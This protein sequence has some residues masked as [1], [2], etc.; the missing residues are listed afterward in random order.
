MFVLYGVE[1]DRFENDYASF[2]NCVHPLDR[3]RVLAEVSE[4]LRE[5]NS[6]T[7][8]FRVQHPEGERT[9]AARG[10]VRRDPSGRVRILSGANWAVDS[11][12]SRAG[13][14]QETRQNLHDQSKRA[15]RIDE[16]RR[17]LALSAVELEAARRDLEAFGG[18]I[19]HEL[20]R[21]LNQLREFHRLL[22]EALEGRWSEAAARFHEVIDGCLKHLDSTLQ[23]LLELA[24]SSGTPLLLER[25][26]PFGDLF[27]DARASLESEAEGRVIE[28]T[29]GPLGSADCS[30]PLM[31]QVFHNLLSNALKFTRHEPVARISVR[32]EHPPG[33]LRIICEDNGVGFEPSQAE[34]LFQPFQR[35]HGIEEFEG[36]GLGLANVARIVE[37]HGGSLSASGVVGA[38][39]RFEVTLRGLG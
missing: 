33:F 2:E 3:Q 37:R 20:T 24:R 26:V 15:Q 21:P 13:T 12:L 29:V 9:I 23:G 28:W 35:L 17:E 10:A 8:E 4:S 7:S 16:S 19:S 18:A 36:T 1:P 39:A 14:D 38:G 31:L 6:F 30:R 5:G 22:W 25:Q 27:R 34:R 11:A 32:S